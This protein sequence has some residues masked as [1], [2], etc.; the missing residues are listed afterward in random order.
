MQKRKQKEKYTDYWKL[1]E[2]KRN[3]TMKCMS[4][5]VEITMDSHLIAQVH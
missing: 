4:R 3:K 1:R 2:Y 5:R